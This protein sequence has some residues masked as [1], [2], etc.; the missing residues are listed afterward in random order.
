V[1][2]YFDPMLFA[3]HGKRGMLSNFDL[4]RG[5]EGWNAFNMKRAFMYHHY[6]SDNPVLH[7]VGPLKGGCT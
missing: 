5:S 3:V 6:G 1:K 4:P 2:N 7:Q